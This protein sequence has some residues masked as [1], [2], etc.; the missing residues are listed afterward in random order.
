MATYICPKCK[1]VVEGQRRTCPKGHATMKEKSLG[2]AF[3]VGVGVAIGLSFLGG[4]ADSFVPGARPAA[5]YIA[6]LIM[7]AA[8]GLGILNWAR[9][10]NAPDP[11]PQLGKQELVTAMGLFSAMIVLFIIAIANRLLF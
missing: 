9:W 2:M 11:M 7:V 3:L 4:L 6:L 8:G 1:V 10:S 5:A